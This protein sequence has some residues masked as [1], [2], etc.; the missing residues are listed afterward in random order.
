MLE[1]TTKKQQSHTTKTC[2]LQRITV[3]NLI[4]HEI[5]C[6]LL[7]T[8]IKPLG[9]RWHKCFRHPSYDITCM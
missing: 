9:P 8:A 4:I 5:F 2:K 3:G 1:L 6:F 7:W